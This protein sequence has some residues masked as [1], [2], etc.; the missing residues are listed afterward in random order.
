AHIVRDGARVAPSGIAEAASA[1]GPQLEHAPRRR[2]QPRGLR[3]LDAHAVRQPQPR[4]VRSPSSTA[5]QPG[6]RDARAIDDG[7]QLGVLEQADVDVEPVAAAVLAGAAGVGCDLD[8]LDDPRVASL[9]DLRGSNPCRRLRDVHQGIRTVAAPTRALADRI[10]RSIRP[11]LAVRAL[12]PPD[13]GAQVASAGRGRRLRLRSAERT[14]DGVDRADRRPAADER[15]RRRERV[16]ERAG[17]CDYLNRSEVPLV[18]PLAAAGQ[19]RD[20]DARARDR[21]RQGAVHGSWALVG[22]AGEV[23]THGRAVDHD[24]DL[25]VHPLVGHTVAVEHPGAAVDTVGNALKPAADDRF[26][27]VE[28]PLDGLAKAVEPVAL[29]DPENLR[30]AG[31]YADE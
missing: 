15:R 24:L 2:L 16:E 8:L 4:A 6:R 20:R 26:A 29:D 31:T 28:H 1:A 18:R 12:A 14:V 22:G 27:V 25:E 21:L 3:A 23:D 10:G 13:E 5:C 17:A 7:R 19:H 9:P 30:R 11:R